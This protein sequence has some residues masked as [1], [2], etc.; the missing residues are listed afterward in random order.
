MIGGFRR[1][2]ALVVALAV[3]GVGAAVFAQDFFRR[4]RQ[5][6]TTLYGNVEYDGRLTFVRIRYAGNFRRD[7]GWA[8]DYPT[9]DI[10]M[11]KILSEL[12]IT[13]ARTDGS[14]VLT[15]DD[16]ELFNYPI[17]YMSEPGFWVPSESE[18]TGLRNYLLK[19]GFIIFDDFRSLEGHWYNLEEQM[20]RVL[21]QHRFVQIDA[22]SPI[23][24]SFFEIASLEF[25]TSYG[26]TMPTYWAMFEDNDTTKRIIAIA[27]VDGDLGE[28]WE[29]SATGL[30]PVDL[31]N[32]A[33]KFGMNYFIYGLTH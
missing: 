6:S 13:P 28:Y 24:N 3:L 18:A 17:A 2:T 27:N 10:H 8:H 26:G 16:P 29:Y 14:N 4:Q 25:L 12:S 22:K 7:P 21:P 32:E 5:R 15:L 30:F 9:A 23:F 19:G 11:M 33:Y 20:R 1:G 31:S